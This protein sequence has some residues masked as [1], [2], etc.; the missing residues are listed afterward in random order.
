[1]SSIKQLALKG[2]VWTVASYGVSQVLRFGSNLILSRLLF[3]ELFGL[4]ALVNVFIVGLHLFSDIGIGPS[5]IQN[6][7]GD[8]PKFLNTAWTLQIIRSFIIWFFCIIVAWPAAQLYREPQLLW[9]IPVTGL[10]TIISGFNSTGLDTLERHMAIRKLAIFQLV[11]QLISLSIM[12]TWAW[13]SP[14]IWALVGSSLVSSLIAMLCSHRLVPSLA[15]RFT[16]DSESAREIFSFGKWI[17]ASTA[18]TF[19]AE[20]SDRLM[21]GKLLSFEM[22][23]VYG[24]AFTLSDMPRQVL[25]AVGSKVLFPAF[26]KLAD[27]PRATVRAKILKHRFLLLISMA[28]A[29][30]WLVSFG[31][32]LVS[33]LFD[34]RYAEAAWML[35]LLALGIWPRVLTQTIDQV[36]FAVGQPRYPTY[37]CL[38]KFV[39]MLIGLPVGFHLS[40]IVGA[41]I[42]VALNDL[43]YYVAVTYGLYREKL[44]VFAQ[45][46]QATL[47]FLA[48]TTLVL[49][50]RTIL[51]FGLPFSGLF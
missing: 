12:L 29:L 15:N 24:V 3:P 50:A 48:F 28:F 10:G 37:G 14:S 13:V 36:F 33:I 9:L 31:D 46:V 49:L 45:D 42:V 35:P 11:L 6:K 20:Q 23:G 19:L 27:L 1:M 4:M 18:I 25:M 30:T 2:T 43:P 7:R 39:F 40:G 41:V 17:F 16:W 44:P 32:F 51:G 5:I 22:L 21:L 47:L 34:D 8:D 38:F 26:S